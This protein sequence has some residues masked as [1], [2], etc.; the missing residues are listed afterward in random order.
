MSPCFSPSNSGYTAS[1]DTVKFAYFDAADCSREGE[2]LQNILGREFVFVVR[3]PFLGSAFFNHVPGVFPPSPKEEVVRVNAN[4]VV[5]AMENTF[6]I[7]D[8][9]IEYFPRKTVSQ[10]AASGRLPNLSVS[11]LVGATTPT[12]TPIG[13]LN[14]LPKSLLK[15]HSVRASFECHA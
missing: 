11:V 14:L 15:R 9:P 10:K 12:P 8:F 4:R 2:N 13:L 1:A 5:A 3:L 6:S 7:W